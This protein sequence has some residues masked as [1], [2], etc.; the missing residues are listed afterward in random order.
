[1]DR[2]REKLI[3]AVIYFTKNTE[4][5]HKL[6]LMKLFY[7]LDFWHFKETGRSVTGLD[8]KAWRD[9]P[10]PPSLFYEI[11]PEN[12]PA[13]IKEYFF[14]E[15][16][17]FQNSSG[18]CLR[19]KTKNKKK[20]NSEVFTKRE[21]E[22]LER[23]AYTFRNAKAQDMTDSTHLSN[24][25]WSK[26]KNEKGDSATIDYMLALDNEPNSLLPEDV[27][28]RI[29]LDNETKELLSRL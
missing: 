16:E 26:T 11:E 17:K 4:H 9:G 24:S 6:K 23:V 1:M 20:F 7:Y 28:E 10:V 2:Q 27:E 12:N 13:D 15:Y 3:N 19:I 5:C 29:K 14:I 21:L 18:Q 22:I 8:Y 25:P